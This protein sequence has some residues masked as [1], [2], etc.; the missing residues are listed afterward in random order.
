MHIF[1]TSDTPIRV[2]LRGL[3]ELVP[4]GL[5][6]PDFRAWLTAPVAGEPLYKRI[7]QVLLPLRILE[8]VLEPGPTAE[9]VL[10]LFEERPI[11]NLK[12]RMARHRHAVSPKDAATLILHFIFESY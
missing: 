8:L 1:P 3:T 12:A 4:A 9:A 6:G 7:L 11:Y 2:R 10:S 5:E